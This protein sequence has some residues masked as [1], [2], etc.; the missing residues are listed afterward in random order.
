MKN[1]AMLAAVAMLGFSLPSRAASTTGQTIS[2]IRIDSSG[3]GIIFLTLAVSGKPACGAILGSGWAFDTNTAGGR[4]ILS[5]ITS[6]KLAGRT[7]DI[8][9]TGA[10]GIYGGNVEDVQELVVR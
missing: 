4:A 2:H 3:K 1:I 9:G 7:V 6:A 5:S 8:V 10:C